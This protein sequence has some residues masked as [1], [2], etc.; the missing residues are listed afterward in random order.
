M[1][2][3]NVTRTQDTGDQEE[4][5]LRD[6]PLEKLWGGDFWAAGIFFRYQ[7]PCTNFLGRSMNI[8]GLIGVHELFYLIF[9]C[10]NIFLVLPRH[11]VSNGPSLMSLRQ[12]GFRNLAK[13]AFW[14]YSAEVKDHKA[15]SGPSW[16]RFCCLRCFF[17]K[18]VLFC[19][20]WKLSYFKCT[21]KKNVNSVCFNSRKVTFST[22]EIILILSFIKKALWNNARAGQD[23]PRAANNWK[24]YPWSWEENMYTIFC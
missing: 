13:L 8:L 4:K 7:I 18:N 5:S 3:Q 22:A 24:F 2:L 1:R 14:S 16:P 19:L 23:Y 10:D 17:Q 6:V 11:K 21:N 15:P 20:F 12:N 9:P